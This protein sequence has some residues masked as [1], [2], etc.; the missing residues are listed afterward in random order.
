MFSV[1]NGELYAQENSKH[2]HY[3]NVLGTSFDIDIDATNSKAI[4]PAIEQMLAQIKQLELVLSTWRNDSEISQLNTD[5]KAQSLSA[6][7][8]EVLDLCQHWR[9]KSQQHFS[10]RMGAL[11][12]VWLQ[13]VTDKAIPDRVELRALASRVE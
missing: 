6:E 2:F 10:C 9:N 13:A 7:L 11:K 3:A 4:E 12:K 5:K 1:V 8:S